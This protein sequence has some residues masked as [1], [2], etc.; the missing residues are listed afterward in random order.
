M[1][2][3]METSS[4]IEWVAGGVALVIFLSALLVVYTIGKGRPHS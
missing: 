3:L 2:T 4:H 1:L